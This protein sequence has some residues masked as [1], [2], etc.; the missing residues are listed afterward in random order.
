MIILNEKLLLTISAEKEQATI[1]IEAAPDA[2]LYNAG[3]PVGAG[4]KNRNLCRL[5]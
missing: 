3:L 4:N 1:H 5:S 2:S